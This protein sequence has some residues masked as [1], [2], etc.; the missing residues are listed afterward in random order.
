MDGEELGWGKR[1][2]LQLE[3]HLADGKGQRSATQAASSRRRQLNHHPAPSQ[4]T[5]KL[6]SSPSHYSVS[7]ASLQPERDTGEGVVLDTI[8][9]HFVQQGA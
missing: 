5:L 3:P 1:T 4:I 6:H 8:W 2:P 7:R 9:T